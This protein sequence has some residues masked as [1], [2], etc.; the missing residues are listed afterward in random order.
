MRLRA[1]ITLKEASYAGNLGFEEMVRFYRAA[2][3]TEI[4]QME[5]VIKKSDW[6]A[7]KKLIEK[8]L[9]TSLS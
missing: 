5:K 1:F 6:N 3:D 7:F 4:D 9:G 8:V 2:S